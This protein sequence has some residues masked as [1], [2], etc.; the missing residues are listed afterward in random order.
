VCFIVSLLWLTGLFSC[1]A[2]RFL[3]SFWHS[4][5]ITLSNYELVVVC[6]YR[7]ST[8]PFICTFKMYSIVGLVVVSYNKKFN[9]LIKSI[10]SYCYCFLYC[11]R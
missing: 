4:V 8:I 11:F 3:L 7:H 2:S 5:S 9:F 1:S 10:F 6:I